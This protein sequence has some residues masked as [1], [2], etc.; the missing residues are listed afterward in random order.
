MARP[1]DDAYWRDLESHA[2]LPEVQELIRQELQ[3]GRI[4]VRANPDGSIRIMPAGKPET[5]EPIE[6]QPSPASSQEEA[7]PPRK[8]GFRGSLA[9]R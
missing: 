7:S 1:G 2:Q 4:R 3:M 8:V 6:M 9:R 5:R